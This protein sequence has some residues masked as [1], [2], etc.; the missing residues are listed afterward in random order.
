MMETEDSFKGPVNLGN[1]SEFTIL[2]FA[3][4]V[5]DK[6][7]SDSQIIHCPSPE[8]DPTKRKPD[9]SLAKEKLNW[10]PKV[11]LDEGLDRTIEYY[12]KII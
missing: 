6:T 11:M 7:G 3:R 4:M 2:N 10:E 8:D 1:P 5:I 9:I 12:E